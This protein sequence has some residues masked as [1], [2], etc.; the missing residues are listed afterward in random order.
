ML[1]FCAMRKWILLILLISLF[2]CSRKETSLLDVVP[3]NAEIIVESADS[4]IIVMFDSLLDAHVDRAMVKNGQSMAVVQMSDKSFQLLTNPTKKDIQEHKIYDDPD[5][6]RLQK[7]LGQNVKA[8]LY[9]RHPE[10]W[11]MLDVLPEGKD[12]VMN[13]YALA[14]DSASA[15]RPLKYQLPVK[16]SV[17]NILPSDTRYMYHLGM[18]DYASY[19][20]SFCDKE[21]VATFNKKYGTDVEQK[22]LNYLSEVSLNKIGKSQREVFVGR[23]NDP[24][25][26]IKFMERLAS[27]AGVNASQNCQGYTLYD[28]GKNTFIPDIFGD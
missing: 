18:S 9:Y 8:H 6:A 24:S 27:K 22:L 14:A 25:A 21:K 28:L 17:V 26:V 19:W 15:W 16:N 10:G 1:Y 12:L 23:M 7:T 4:A 11:A 20:E 2:S 3:A 5:F 13:G